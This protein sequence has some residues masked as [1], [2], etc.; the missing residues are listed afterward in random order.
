MAA[1]SEGEPHPDLARVCSDDLGQGAVLARVR[2][3]DLSLEPFRRIAGVLFPS[4]LASSMS[5]SLF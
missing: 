2:S 5:V 1:G 3:D 4:V